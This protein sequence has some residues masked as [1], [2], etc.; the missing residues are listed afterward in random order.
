M[1]GFKV[2]NKLLLVTQDVIYILA[3]IF[4]CTFNCKLFYTVFLLHL[5]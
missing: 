2:T 4:N 1:H 5:I 3:Q